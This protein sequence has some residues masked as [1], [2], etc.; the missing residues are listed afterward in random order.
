MVVRD[1]VGRKRYIAF[2]VAS[3]DGDLSRTR[4]SKAI[5]RKLAESAHSMPFEVILIAGGRGIARTNQRYATQLSSLLNSFSNDQDG[6]ELKTLKTSGTIR[7]L[8]EKY[9]QSGAR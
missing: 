9:M 6:F 1:K 2:D 5:G 7:T 8:K 3:S 4:L